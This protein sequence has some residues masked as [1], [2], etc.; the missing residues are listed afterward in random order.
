MSRRS[1]RPVDHPYMGT[2]VSQ[3]G[4]Q[5]IFWRKNGDDIHAVLSSQHPGNTNWYLLSQAEQRH[6]QQIHPL[7]PHLRS[8]ITGALSG[9]DRITEQHWHPVP[10]AFWAVSRRTLLQ[11]TTL[12][13]MS[14]CCDEYG[15][16]RVRSS[17]GIL[18]VANNNVLRDSGSHRA[19]GT[20]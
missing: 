1:P 10:P 14:E 18:L 5:P 12:L 13:N 15:A 4:P 9:Y 3:T 8:G 2:Q 11:S 20:I 19:D 16:E 7:S 6:R 17:K